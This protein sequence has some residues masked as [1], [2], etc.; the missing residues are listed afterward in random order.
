MFWEDEGQE[1]GTC[2]SS[3][4]NHSKIRVPGS[5]GRLREGW[6]GEVQRGVGIL[7]NLGESREMACTSAI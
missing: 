1:D 4:T 6:S 3:G 5:E 7:E 2:R